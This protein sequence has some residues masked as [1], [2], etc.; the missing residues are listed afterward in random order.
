MHKYHK[1]MVKLLFVLSIENMVKPCYTI[2]NSG[3]TSP[4]K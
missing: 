1:C 4:T 3:A 2:I